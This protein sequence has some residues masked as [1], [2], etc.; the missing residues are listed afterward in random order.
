MTEFFTYETLTWPEIKDLPRDTPL[1]LPLGQGYAT[2]PLA[3][4]L[5][6][7]FRIGLLPPLP[8]GWRGSGLVVADHLLG[9]LVGNL[10]NSLRDD[11]FSRVL[12]LC[13]QG[14]GLGAARIALPQVVSGIL[15]G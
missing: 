9:R 13:P 3:E 8:F 15:A 6:H 4:A 11:G 7:P 12:A 14:V 10:L 5:A 1:I 2:N